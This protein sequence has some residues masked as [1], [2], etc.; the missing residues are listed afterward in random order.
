MHI[1]QSIISSLVTE[2]QSLMIQAKQV[3]NRCLNIMD[4]NG[5]FDDIEPQFI[6]SA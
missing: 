1:G 6:S 3:E 2:C 4:V 5:T